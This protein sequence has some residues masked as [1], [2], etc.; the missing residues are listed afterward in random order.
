M[1]GFVACFIR[2]QA[3]LMFRGSTLC[4]VSYVCHYICGLSDSPQF[5]APPIECSCIRSISLGCQT[6]PASD[7]LYRQCGALLTHTCTT[8]CLHCHSDKF[9]LVKV[10]LYI[11]V[12]HPCETTE[13]ICLPLH[14]KS[15]DTT[16]RLQRLIG[17]L[18]RALSTSKVNWTCELRKR[19]FTSDTTTQ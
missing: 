12:K 13:T 11:P 5:D 6:T 18:Q 1:S 7:S 9:H 8:T 10:S 19:S 4:I 17:R 3:E 16:G 2:G 14:S 15:S